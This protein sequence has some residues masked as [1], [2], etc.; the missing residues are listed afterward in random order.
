MIIRNKF[1]YPE[2]VVSAAMA[3][4]YRPEPNKIGVTTL[5]DA[6]LIRHLRLTRWDDLEID[7]DDTLIRLQGTGWHQFLEKHVNPETTM[8]EKR[9][10]LPF[11]DFEAGGNK[12]NI[13]LRGVSDAYRLNGDIDDHKLMSA[14]SFVFGND[15]YKQLNVY[16]YM[17]RKSGYEVKALW[18]NA[19]IKDWSQYK[20]AQ[21]RQNYPQRR[22]HRV[23]LP[24]WEI[25]RQHEFVESRLRDHLE[26]PTRECTPEEKWQS[27]TK[28]AVRAV[29][30]KKAYRLLDTEVEANRMAKGMNTQQPK[31]NY[32]VEKRPGEP[33][34]CL[35]FCDVR[36]ICP[37]APKKERD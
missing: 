13:L 15:Y 33:R 37:F 29:P 25:E 23:N 24:L 5:V 6:P 30:N 22:F 34:R 11:K 28:W 32:V 17:I 26:A 7:V 9:W 2:E 27:P 36:H 21:D 8:G 3:S 16:A 35:E 19:L 1:R 10:E 31:K 4:C 14:W 12:Y 20:A 18:L